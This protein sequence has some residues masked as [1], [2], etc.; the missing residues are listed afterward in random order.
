MKVKCQYIL[1]TF[2]PGHNICELFININRFN[3]IICGHTCL[4]IPHS[5]A[6]RV[7]HPSVQNLNKAERL[8][9]SYDIKSGMECM[10]ILL[11]SFLLPVSMNFTR[12]IGRSYIF[13]AVYVDISIHK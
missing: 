13:G 4:V 12:G 2:A 8:S 7:G 5:T 6:L 11:F 10:F 9:V 3:L 1:F